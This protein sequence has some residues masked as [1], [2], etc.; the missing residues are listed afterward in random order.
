MQRLATRGRGESQSGRTPRHRVSF[1]QRSKSS[2]G[3]YTTLT[4]LHPRHNTPPQTV[5]TPPPPIDLTEDNEGSAEWE[6]IL[7]NPTQGIID[8]EQSLRHKPV[9]DLS[10]DDFTI[11]KTSDGTSL[12]V[13][14]VVD[15]IYMLHS[16]LTTFEVA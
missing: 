16:E 14:R 9:R 10:I 13:A 5:A 1:S 7:E 3:D 6:A 2:G 4:T 8:R 12:L 15:A 11:D